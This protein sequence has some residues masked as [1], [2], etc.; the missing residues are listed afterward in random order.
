MQYIDGAVA[1]FDL[2]IIGGFYNS[3]KTYIES[4]LLGVL[5]DRNDDISTCFYSVGTVNIGLSNNTRREL[6]NQLKPHWK[7]VKTN[8]ENRKT[9]PEPPEG[10]IWGTQFPD[11]WIDPRSSV[12]LKVIIFCFIEKCNLTR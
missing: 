4:Y 8:K 5:K 10:M 1:D 9:I 2:M 7:I 11:V 12:I 3:R 6:G